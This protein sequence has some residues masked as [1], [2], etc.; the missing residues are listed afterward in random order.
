MSSGCV[1][2]YRAKAI[3]TK[4]LVLESK[5]QQL[6]KDFDENKES[7]NATLE[8]ISSRFERFNKDIL[9]AI[10]R[11]RKGSAEDIGD[12]EALKDQITRQQG[13]LSRLKFELGNLKN[14]KA[15]Q[16]QKQQFPE[17]KEALYQQ[18][19]KLLLEKSYNEAIRF[20]SQF[21]KRYPNDVRADDSLYHIAEAYYQQQQFSD[22][23]IAIKQIIEEYPNENQADKAL[24]LLHDAYLAMKKCS[25]ARSALEYLKERYPRSN[26]KR[27]ATRKLERLK[28]K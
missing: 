18:A 12:I 25:K 8:N 16:T 10:D 22:S 9:T 1:T 5:F 15:A 23:V 6:K 3:E 20:Y 14:D 17:D 7:Q 4:I 27:N 13:E 19:E 11:L 21:V 2:H 26:Q 28:C 24:I